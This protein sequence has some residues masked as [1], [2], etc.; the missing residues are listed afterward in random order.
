MGLEEGA[1]AKQQLKKA[2]E[3]GRWQESM[4]F[5]DLQTLSMNGGQD[6]REGKISQEARLGLDNKKACRSREPG[7]SP[8]GDG[9]LMTQSDFCLSCCVDDD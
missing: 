9:F 6:A 7:R 5:K 2:W 1:T 4:A 8:K 3:L